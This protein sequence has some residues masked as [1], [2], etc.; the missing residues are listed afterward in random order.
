M[1]VNE[2]GGGGGEWMFSFCLPAACRTTASY[3]KAKTGLHLVLLWK[4]ALE[5]SVGRFTN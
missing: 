2:R 1:E 4:L 3:N 5:L